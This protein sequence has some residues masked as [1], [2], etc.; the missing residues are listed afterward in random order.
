MD[1]YNGWKNQA[2]WSVN[3]LHMEKIVAMLNDGFDEES[4][5]F[6]IKD[7]C[8]SEDMNLYGRDMFYSA[9]A[10]IDW[11][12]IFNRAKENMEQLV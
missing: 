2:T 4:I 8:K 10:T 6:H 3:V 5:K 9:W 7:A 11:Y 12:T 1:D